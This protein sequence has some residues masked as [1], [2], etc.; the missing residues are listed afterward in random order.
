MGRVFRLQPVKRPPSST[1]T[2]KPHFHLFCLVLSQH[3]YC[4]SG[5]GILA[6]N[7]SKIPVGKAVKGLLGENGHDALGRCNTVCNLSCGIGNVCLCCFVTDKQTIFTYTFVSSYEGSPAEKDRRRNTTAEKTFLLIGE[8]G[9]SCRPTF[10][11]C[12][13]R[14]SHSL[15]DAF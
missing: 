3:A 1:P 12:V 6:V 2:A 14:D 9:L 8:L 7:I 15:P 13:F 10:F 5:W 4:V 11:T